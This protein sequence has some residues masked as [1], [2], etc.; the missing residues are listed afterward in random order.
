MIAL[1][2][3]KNISGFLNRYTIIKIGRLHIRLHR[4]N[5][6]DITPFYHTHPYSY[7]S[8]IIRGG[9]IEKLV[10]NSNILTKKHKLFSFIFRSHNQYHRIES[11]KAKTTTL[12]IAFYRKDK[13][14]WKLKHDDNIIIKEYICPDHQGIYRCI[15]NNKMKFCKFIPKEG[16]FIGSSNYDIAK[17]ETRKS[18]YQN[19][20]WE[21]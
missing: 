12:F 13:Y 4:I 7:L 18:I 14:D 9:Y 15:I 17:Y 19:R 21:L 10:K 16:W 6:P 2:Q 8:I 3:Y 5:S 11:C 1:K 20:K